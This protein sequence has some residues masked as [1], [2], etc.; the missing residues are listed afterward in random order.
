MNDNHGV[1]IDKFLYAVRLYKT[2]SLASDACRLGRVLVNNNTIKPSKD[3]VTGQIIIVKKAPVTYTYK[4]IGLTE[5]RVGA[6]LVE[7]YIEDLTPDSE[8]EKLTNMKETGAM[9]MRRKRSGRPTKK[10][11][12][13]MDRLKDKLIGW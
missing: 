5:N 10:E 1:R 13:D 4:I 9:F 8:K 11:R 2:R 12:R 3:V 6:K 7:N